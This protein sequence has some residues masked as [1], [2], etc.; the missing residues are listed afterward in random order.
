M[1][2]HCFC[3][4]KNELLNEIPSARHYVLLIRDPRVAFLNL[5]VKQLFHRC[6][7]SDILNIRYLH[8][9]S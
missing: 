8:Y 5:R 4:Q 9:N 7:I 3:S 6:Y 1:G 2:G